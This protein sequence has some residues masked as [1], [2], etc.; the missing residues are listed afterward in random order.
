MADV[1][2]G[3]SA[4][5]MA[6]AAREG[7]RALQRLTSEQRGD[8]LRRMARAL[9]DNAAAILEENAKDVADGREL[10]ARGELGDALVG[11]L[12]MSES[13]ARQARF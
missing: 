4:R 7:G 5:A 13:K 11:R 9:E 12:I 6:V 2:D 3:T 8:L 1:D 10:N